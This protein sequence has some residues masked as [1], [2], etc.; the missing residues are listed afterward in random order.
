MIEYLVEKIR[1]STTRKLLFES[2]LDFI[3]QFSEQITPNF[4]V[5]IDG[6]FVTLKRNPNDIDIVVFLEGFVFLNKQ[7]ELAKIQQEYQAK[8]LDLYFV[9]IYPKDHKRHFWYISK[10]IEWKHLFT[11]TRQRQRTGKS[12]SK[13]FLKIEYYEQK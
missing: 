10:Q 3:T 9:R 7:N 13:G 1:S 2:Y 6:S 12:F 4:T 5:W 11:K 8:D